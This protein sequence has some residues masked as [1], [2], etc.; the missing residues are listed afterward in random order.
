M[1]KPPSSI[2]DLDN[3]FSEN[4]VIKEVAPEKPKAPKKERKEYVFQQTCNFRVDS[5][6]KMI[7]YA[8]LSLSNSQ[9]VYDEETGKTRQA[10]IL[11]GC[12]TMWQDEQDK[13]DPN[14]VKRN[15]VS[16]QFVDGRLT[17]PALDK[18]TIKF[19]LSCSDFEGCEK[20]TQ[21]RKNRYKLLDTEA[22]EAKELERK[23]KQKDATDIA[24]KAN[25]EDL[26]VHYTYLGGN[27]LN[28]HGE[29]KS[30]DGLRS[31]YVKKAEQ[32]YQLFL[33]TVGNP[34]VKMHMMVKKAFEKTFIIYLDGQFQWA[35]TKAY[36]CQ[37]PASYQ[38]NP[39]GYLAELLLTNDGKA[40]RSRLENM[41]K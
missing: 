5:E 17:V 36:M 6:T 9:M 37:V 29:A 3:V 19:L 8:P 2:S 25:M 24:W 30:E 10:R 14:Y 33:D 7:R 28:D 26:I 35:D 41:E 38:T 12:S 20:P 27:L 34:I 22:A 18:N 32:Q 16:L 1:A 15:A 31:D 21:N 23:K 4:G 11:R 40:I 13:L 39:T